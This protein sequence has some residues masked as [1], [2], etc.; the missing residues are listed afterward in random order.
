MPIFST[1]GL[2]LGGAEVGRAVWDVG[3]VGAALAY[4]TP[5]TTWSRVSQNSPGWGSLRT[6]LGVRDAGNPPWMGASENW[7]TP[8]LP[9]NGA[10]KS[11][12][13]MGEPQKRPGTG[14]PQERL[15]WG[16]CETP[17]RGTG[18]GGAR[19][20]AACWVWSAVC[21]SGVSHSGVGLSV[22][23]LSFGESLCLSGEVSLSG[24]VVR[25]RGLVFEGVFALSGVGS[26]WGR[27]LSVQ[28]RGLSYR[29]VV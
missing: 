8:E 20:G 9:E 5:R 28:G 7:G 21:V 1:Q 29:G 18:R 19:P 15:G 26:L 4:R 13:G 23:G 22:R 10:L 16:V 6:A 17:S 25:G 14:E 27:G 11:H 24:S 3:T 2:R 12:A